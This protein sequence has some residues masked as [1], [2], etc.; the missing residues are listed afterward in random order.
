MSPMPAP[1]RP[2]GLKLV[3]S[4]VFFCGYLLFQIIY[5]ALPWF[6]PGFDRFTWHM[7][8]GLGDT[9]RFTVVFGDG[10]RREVGNPLKAG[11]DALLLGPSVN[12]RRFL[13]PWLC[14]NWI[15]AETIMMRSY[16]G[17]EET[18]ACRSIAP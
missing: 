3:L 13:P 14:T 2:S 15:G 1:S 17:R 12:Q 18:V 10:S 16:S 4:G 5:P 7:Y 11:G 6:L 8:S 9:P